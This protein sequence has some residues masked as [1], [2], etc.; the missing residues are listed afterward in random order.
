MVTV[1]HYTETYWEI[2]DK[3]EERIV[4]HFFDE[5]AAK[6]YAAWLNETQQPS[7]TSATD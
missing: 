4:A 1:E 3:M 7:E 5:A 2:F 6:R